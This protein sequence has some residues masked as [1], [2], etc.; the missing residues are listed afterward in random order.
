MSCETKF[1]NINI[2]FMKGIKL[3]ELV[4]ERN[5]MLTTLQKENMDYI[6]ELGEC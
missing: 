5:E 6:K 2:S 3:L 1:R 4:K